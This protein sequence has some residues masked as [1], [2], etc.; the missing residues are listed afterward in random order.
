MGTFLF[1][2]IIAIEIEENCKNI[3]FVKFIFVILTDQS[4]RLLGLQQNRT[5]SNQVNVTNKSSSARMIHPNGR[6]SAAS[7]S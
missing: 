7:V 5:E 1:S 3:F 4:T 6:N 2:Y